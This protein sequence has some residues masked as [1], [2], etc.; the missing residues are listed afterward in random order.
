[1]RGKETW[2]IVLHSL[3]VTLP[4]VRSGWDKASSDLRS[5]VVSSKARE[6]RARASEHTDTSQPTPSLLSRMSRLIKGSASEPNAERLEGAAYSSAEPTPKR[7]Y[8]F[9]TSKL[10]LQTDQ[11]SENLFRYRN[12]SSALV[13][14]SSPVREENQEGAASG[15]ASSTTSKKQEN[16]DD[17]KKK[18]K[19]AAKK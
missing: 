15:S 10:A 17:D 9:A 16:D 1:M 14:S 7:K 11:G 18:T 6:T 2:S 12:F 19:A 3:C 4:S 8:G 5:H 13:R